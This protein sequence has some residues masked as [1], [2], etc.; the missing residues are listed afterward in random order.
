LHNVGN[1][2]QKRGTLNDLRE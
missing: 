2:S 1:Q